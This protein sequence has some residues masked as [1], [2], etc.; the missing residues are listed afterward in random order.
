MFADKEMILTSF[1][2]GLQRNRCSESSHLDNYTVTVVTVTTS[3]LTLLLFG[4]LA[5]VF[6]TEKGTVAD[7]A[8]EQKYREWNHK[9]F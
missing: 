5:A 1:W 2:Q 4:Y 8:H 3:S 6:D 9:W 7:A